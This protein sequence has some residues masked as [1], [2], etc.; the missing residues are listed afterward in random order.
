MILRPFEYVESK[1]VDEAVT[2]LRSAR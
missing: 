1:T 2:A